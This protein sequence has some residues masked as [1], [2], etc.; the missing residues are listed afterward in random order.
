MI[1]RQALAAQAVGYGGARLIAAQFQWPGVPAP[2][3]MRAPAGHG[4]LEPAADTAARPSDN[5]QERIEPS[6]WD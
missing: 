3:A 6:A 1:G 5:R 4:M 2:H